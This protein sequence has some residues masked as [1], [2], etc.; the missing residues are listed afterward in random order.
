MPNLDEI[1]QHLVP[2]ARGAAPPRAAVALPGGDAAITSIGP[3]AMSSWPA[4]FVIN[5]NYTSLAARRRAAAAPRP[6]PELQIK[7]CGHDEH[8]RPAWQN[9]YCL[10]D[11]VKIYQ[12]ARLARQPDVRAAARVR[13]HS[14]DV[15]AHVQRTYGLE[16]GV[17]NSTD[18]GHRCLGRLQV[19]PHQLPA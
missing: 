4:H 2:A 14:H 10:S 8:Q 12:L 17:R 1:D 18:I 15:S 13:A 9:V 7:Q 11:Q 16:V 5:L 6:A 3:H 19:C